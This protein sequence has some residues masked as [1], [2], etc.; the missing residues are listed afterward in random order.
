MK[1]FIRFIKDNWFIILLTYAIYF[2]GFI[3][4]KSI[5]VNAYSLNEEGNVVSD[6]LVDI[7]VNNASFN[8]S[9]NTTTV[10]F[11]IW[12][13]PYQ[14]T[15]FYSDQQIDISNLPLNV[16]YQLK[17]TITLTE[18]TNLRF[19]FGFNGTETMSNNSYTFDS[20][21]YSYL[22]TIQKTDTR[23]IYKNITFVYGSSQPTV[24]EP[25]GVW[26]SQSYVDSLNQN[27]VPVANAILG[28][29]NSSGSSLGYYNV[30][31]KLSNTGGVLWFNDILNFEYIKS[32]NSNATQY[33]LYVFFKDNL[34][35]SGDYIFHVPITGEQTFNMKLSQFN[36]DKNNPTFDVYGGL[37]NSTIIADIY[38]YVAGDY[39]RNECTTFVNGSCTFNVNE[40][41]LDTSYLYFNVLGFGQLFT[42]QTAFPDY[43]GYANNSYALGYTNGYN[44]GATSGEKVGYEN[45]FVNGEKEGY[46]NGFNAG[47]LHQEENG[48]NTLGGMVS[49][50]ISTPFNMLSDF[51]NF[52]FLG[53]NLSDFFFSIMSL[54]IVIWLI[55]EF[56]QV[57]IMRKLF[58]I[59]LPVLLVITTLFHF[60]SRDFMFIDMLSVFSNMS[61]DNGFSVL[62][63]AKNT[64]SNVSISLENIKTAT[65][66]Y[67]VISNL[68]SMLANVFLGFGEL[69][70]C[71]GMYLIDL[72]NNVGDILSYLLGINY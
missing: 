19:Q 44:N 15:P 63:E 56:L 60:Q 47:L 66:A 35:T 42:N 34:I 20:G 55:K 24:Y 29:A 12:T 25:Y 16:D 62:V 58:I 4:G 28:L 37:N 57:L 6:N 9:F 40:K 31:D 39:P 32:L 30:T 5:I 46:F 21:I 8:L 53:V 1:K 38:P 3:C 59:L 69:I 45:G 64:F 2:F 36:G 33:A 70:G 50:L 13:N 18:R 68:G 71:V 23:L 65:N 43:F 14:T 7:N 26:Y 22:V 49:A 51:F 61:F 52:N 48:P 27:G 11:R 17:K 41:V 10:F 72:V 67:D 54:L